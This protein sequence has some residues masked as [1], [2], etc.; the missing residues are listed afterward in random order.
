M[1]ID[2]IPMALIITLTAVALGCSEDEV[3][4][5]TESLCDDPDGE[6]DKPESG[7]DDV[8]DGDGDKSE[9]ACRP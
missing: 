6:C 5:E 3:E 4:S 2:S 1:R 7:N 9:A 8:G